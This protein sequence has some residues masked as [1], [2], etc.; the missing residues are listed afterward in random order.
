MC[1][2][3]EPAEAVEQLYVLLIVQHLE[4]LVDGVENGTI[5]CF[6]GS[7]SDRIFQKYRLWAKTALFIFMP[8]ECDWTV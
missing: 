3:V 8:T 6:G 1:Q 7:R 4:E 5:G 2:Q